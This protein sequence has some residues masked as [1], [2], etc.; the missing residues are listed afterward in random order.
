[1]VSEAEKI[2]GKVVI[3]FTETKTK[4]GAYWDSSKNKIFINLVELENNLYSLN[5][6]TTEYKIFSTIVFEML[7]AV[8]T[9][10]DEFAKKKRLRF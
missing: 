5:Q 10:L 3:D 8:N 9:E 6:F 2:R 7:N 4:T 1:M